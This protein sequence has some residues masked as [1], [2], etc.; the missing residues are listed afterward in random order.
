MH[1]RDQLES[2]CC[3]GAGEG[4]IGAELQDGLREFAWGHYLWRP[5][6]YSPSLVEGQAQSHQ[7][8]KP[9]V[10]VS[11]LAGPYPGW[12]WDKYLPLSAG[13]VR[14]NGLPPSKGWESLMKDE[15]IQAPDN[16]EWL[17]NSTTALEK[18]E[19]HVSR[20]A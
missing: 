14:R 9:Q 6:L 13:E 19:A 8:R 18:D 12:K 2:S 4:W 20:C 17:A 3:R 7:N 5:S 1:G 16:L 15:K 11:P 10:V